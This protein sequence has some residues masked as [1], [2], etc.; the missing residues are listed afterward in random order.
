LARIHV[1]LDLQSLLWTARVLGVVSVPVIF[2]AAEASRYLSEDAPSLA[3]Q[4]KGAAVIF[5]F[6]LAALGTAEQW[7]NAAM[8]A[9]QVAALF[10]GSAAALLFQPA[11]AAALELLAPGKAALEARYRVR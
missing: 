11:F 6:F 7:D 10:F 9:V 4:R 5:I 8:T 1:P 2:I 3:L